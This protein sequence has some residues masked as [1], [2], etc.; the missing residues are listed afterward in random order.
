MGRPLEGAAQISGFTTEEALRLKGPG[1]K[2]SQPKSTVL[3]QRQELVFSPTA[4]FP[5]RL[6]LALE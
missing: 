5:T 6:P 1:Q 4:P 3:V 2:P